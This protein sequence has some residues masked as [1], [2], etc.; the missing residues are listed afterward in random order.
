MGQT[1][2]WKDILN[3]WVLFYAFLRNLSC[4]IQ[5]QQSCKIKKS[6]RKTQGPRPIYE[7]HNVRLGQEKVSKTLRSIRHD[8]NDVSWQESR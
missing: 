5:E 7:Q 3:S 6:R 8:R 1:E 4:G 2:G